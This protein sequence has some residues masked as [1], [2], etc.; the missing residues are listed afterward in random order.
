MKNPKSNRSSDNLEDITTSDKQRT[1]T[2]WDF[3]NGGFG[4]GAY[5]L[6]AFLAVMLGYAVYRK[7]LVTAFG[8]EFSVKPIDSTNLYIG[9]AKH[10]D[11]VIAPYRNQTKGKC[12]DWEIILVPVSFGVREP[13]KNYELDNAL[14]QF[15]TAAIPNE[16]RS[17]WRI[18]ATFAYRNGEKAPTDVGEG[19]AEVSYILKRKEKPE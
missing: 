16:D 8:L 4:W 10:G 18:T 13:D 6:A 19:E 1:L 3:L 5:I 7:Q 9:N 17:G 11:L 12:D 2:G 15:K 14:L